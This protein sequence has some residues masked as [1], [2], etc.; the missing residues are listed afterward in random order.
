MNTQRINAIVSLNDK[1]DVKLAYD[2]L[3]SIAVLLPAQDNDPPTVHNTCNSLWLL[4][5][6]YAHLLEAYTNIN[7]DLHDQLKHLSLAAHL[8]MAIYSMTVLI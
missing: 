1:Q 8:I 5:K 3:S 6:V 4:G 2:L 7:L